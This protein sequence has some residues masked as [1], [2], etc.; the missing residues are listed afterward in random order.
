MP[1]LTVGH[2]PNAG[3]TVYHDHPPVV[4][5][6]IL[7]FYK[8]F[9]V[10][11]WQTR[12]AT[13][14]ATLATLL[15]LYGLLDQ[16]A[17][18]RVA[19]LSAACLAAT[20]M[21]LYYGGQPEVLGM[22]LI[23][24]VICS[25]YAYFVFHRNPNVRT[26]ALLIATFALAGATDWPA[27]ILVPIFLI[28]FV[29]TQPSR[30]WVWIFMFCVV[31]AALF[32]LLY[33][34]IKVAADL[35][36]SWMVD[37]FLKR[38]ALGRNLG[39]SP[40]EWF[41]VALSYNVTF[42]TVP[43]LLLATAWLIGLSWR[44][45]SLGNKVPRILLVWGV[46]HVLLGREGTYTHD[47]WWWPLTPGLA[48]AAGFSLDWLVRQTQRSLNLIASNAIFASALFVFAVWTTQSTYAKLH[49]DNARPFTAEE[50]GEAIRAA[51][52]NPDDVALL[53]WNNNSQDFFYGN[54]PLRTGIWSV[55]D[56]QHR[57]CSHTVDLPFGYEQM[58]NAPA[59]GIVFPLVFLQDYH[60]I[61]DYLQLHY[62]EVSLKRELITK[63]R[64]FRFCNCTNRT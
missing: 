14:I 30:Q 26:S 39:F 42:H 41:A 53:V 45:Q 11:E 63:F 23:L 46:A 48:T 59:K 17:S 3:V 44:S 36:W 1:A 29:T 8:F 34:Y 4:P 33:A 13:S 7:P 15:A 37:P 40:A 57:L 21:T 27:F 64:V 43:L 56:L 10:G 20:P 28:H 51:A 16:F 60:E 38:S 24:F 61:L 35:P 18:R 54:R 32:F 19:L 50:L 12:L 5:L 25:V 9:G 62:T 2:S 58:W 52:P 6:L 55:D 22:P 31:G 47:W 49:P